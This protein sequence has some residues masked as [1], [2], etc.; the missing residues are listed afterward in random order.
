LTGSRTLIFNDNSDSTFWEK[1]GGGAFN[2]VGFDTTA[3]VN[4][5]TI[6]TNYPNING[7]PSQVAWDAHT[8]I[9]VAIIFGSDTNAPDTLVQYDISADPTLPLLVESY[10][11]PVNHQ[12][13]NNGCGR[14]IFA[15]D[16]VYALDANN[17]MAAWTL[18]PVLHITQDPSNVVLS[19]SA[20]TPGYT[21]TS[22]P[23]LSTPTTWTPVG[24]GTLV[25]N[26]YFVTNSVGAGALFYRLQK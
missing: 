11:F 20:E 23:S 14:V 2:L 25:G 6:L 18:V 10:N 19:W 17:G 7:S 24:T 16:R 12:A 5:S 15:G 22:S 9:L 3:G 26:Q 4:A 13:N 8:N 21:L 1:H